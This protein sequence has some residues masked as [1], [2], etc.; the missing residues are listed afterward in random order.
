MM[1]TWFNPST[2]VFATTE[3]GQKVSLDDFLVSVN[4]SLSDKDPNERTHYFI[5]FF[6]VHIPVFNINSV[7]KLIAHN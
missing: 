2:P 6:E 5:R 7:A 3:T 4:P 1:A